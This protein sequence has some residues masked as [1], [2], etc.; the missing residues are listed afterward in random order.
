MNFG[1]DAIRRMSLIGQF[2]AISKFA[3][4]LNSGLRARAPSA[5]DNGG[6]Q[7]CD[8]PTA[9]KSIC[10]V[11]SDL[12][13][14]HSTGKKLWGRFATCGGLVNPPDRLYTGP[15]AP[16]ENRRAG[17]NPAPQEHLSSPAEGVSYIYQCRTHN[18]DS[19]Q[20]AGADSGFLRHLSILSH[21]S[22]GAW[23]GIGSEAW[24]RPATASVEPGSTGTRIPGS[25]SPDLPLVAGFERRKPPRWTVMLKVAE[26]AGIGPR[27]V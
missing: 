7:N 4:A 16:V 14:T 26:E 3:I 5:D 23:R 19:R 6:G 18:L 20:V 21:P 12:L 2:R 9:N 1:S 8:A 13:Q 17:Y 27:P 10:S 25:T 15:P 22:N 24:P 11:H